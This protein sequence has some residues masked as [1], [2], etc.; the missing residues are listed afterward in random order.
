[1]VTCHV[2]LESCKKMCSS[3]SDIYLAEYNIYQIIHLR[4]WVDSNI[5][6]LAKTF[7]NITLMRYGKLCAIWASREGKYLLHM[8][9]DGDIFANIN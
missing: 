2:M 1:M 9:E 8:I 5:E 4:L 7:L 3:F 6:K